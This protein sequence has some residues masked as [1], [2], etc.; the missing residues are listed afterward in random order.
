MMWEAFIERLSLKE[1]S[2][3]NSDMC[4]K[5]SRYP[6]RKL[7]TQAAEIPSF[8]KSI[9]KFT[10]ATTSKNLYASRELLF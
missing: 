1:S 6:L 5:I 9:Q 2:Q 10:F 7:R 3:T 8:I 4:L